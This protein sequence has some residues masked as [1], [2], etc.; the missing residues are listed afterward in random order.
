MYETSLIYE[1]TH[2]I[3]GSFVMSFGNT[4]CHPFPEDGFSRSEMQFC[5]R[6]NNTMVIIVW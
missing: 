5:I 2:D 1:M 3:A 4:K 6:D